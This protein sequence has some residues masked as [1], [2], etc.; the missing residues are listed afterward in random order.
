MGQVAYFDIHSTKLS[1]VFR[2]GFR[3]LFERL[4][5]CLTFEVVED[6][7]RAYLSELFGFVYQTLELIFSKNTVVT[8]FLS[9]DVFCCTPKFLG[10]TIT[11]HAYAWPV[12][13]TKVDAYE[14]TGE[15]LWIVKNYVLMYYVCV[16]LSI[17]GDSVCQCMVMM[18]WGLRMLL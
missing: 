9:H 10:A 6:V 16:E 3:G 7:L 5:A 14:Y 8:W 13:I 4:R 11:G 15:I 1:P 18:Y 2:D 12:Q 17:G